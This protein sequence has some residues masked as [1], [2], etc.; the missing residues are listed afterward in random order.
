[1]QSS[2]Y[3]PYLM[4]RTANAFASTRADVEAYRNRPVTS[5]GYAGASCG[6]PGAY[7][8]CD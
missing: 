6:M 7:V 3:N 1:M 5:A 2:G 8:T 4:P